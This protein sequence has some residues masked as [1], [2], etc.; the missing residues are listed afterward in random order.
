MATTTNNG[1][2]TPDDSSLVKD[3][4]SAIRTLGSAIDTTLGNYSR[5]WTAW[6]P[7]ITA[8][9][10]TITTS[11]V[12]YARYYQIG[13]LVLLKFSILVTDNGT[14]ASDLRLTLPVTGISGDNSIG[15]G[16]NLGNGNMLQVRSTSTTGLS[17]N[18]YDNV[19]PVA[20]G[21]TVVGSLVYEAA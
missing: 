19:Y 4:A 17:I 9:S 18:R 6:T 21:Q 15:S 1:W 2:T 5:T 8:G 16:R 14:G 11:S 12:T 3:G 10:G 7:T 13:K 20:S